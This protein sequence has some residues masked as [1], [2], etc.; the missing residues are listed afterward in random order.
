MK[1]EKLKGFEHDG[2]GTEWLQ[3]LA[4]C[5]PKLEYL[6]VPKIYGN[7]DVKSQ[8][9]AISKMQNLKTLKIGN[10]QSGHISEPCKTDDIIHFLE[11]S[12][13]KKLEVLYIFGV[14]DIFPIIMGLIVTCPNLKFISCECIKD[15][16]KEFPKRICIKALFDCLKELQTLNLSWDDRENDMTDYTFQKEDLEEAVSECKKQLQVEA[17]KY[18]GF[19]IKRKISTFDSVH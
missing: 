12:K 14:L 10:F 13:F 18:L 11:N 19:T 3:H 7:M 9:Q 4:N 8:F 16:R 2:N 6:S 1:K 5:C 17:L 15:N